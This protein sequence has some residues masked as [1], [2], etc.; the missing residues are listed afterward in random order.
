V[1][2]YEYIN[3][4]LFFS[5]WLVNDMERE[6]GLGKNLFYKDIS[7]RKASKLPVENLSTEISKGTL[8]S[9]PESRWKNLCFSLSYIFNFG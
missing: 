7:S 5:L 3:F 4:V 2:P 6:E 9:H 8:S 1:F